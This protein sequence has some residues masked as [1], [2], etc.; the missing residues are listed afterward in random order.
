MIEALLMQPG[1]IQEGCTA[2]RTSRSAHLECLFLISLFLTLRVFHCILT[3]RWISLSSERVPKKK[4]LVD[5]CFPNIGLGCSNPEGVRN[6][7]NPQVIVSCVF[8]SA[9]SF[10]WYNWTIKQMRFTLLSNAMV[11]QYI[12]QYIMDMMHILYVQENIKR[13]LFDKHYLSIM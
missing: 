11:P 6:Q 3:V 9:A 4:L 5:G 1:K 10:L 7:V 12:D 13:G 8:N 2:L